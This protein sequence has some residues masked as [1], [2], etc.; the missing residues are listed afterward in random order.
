MSRA[1]KISELNGKNILSKQEIESLRGKVVV[2]DTEGE[3]SK[4]LG[5]KEKGIYGIKFR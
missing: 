2:L 3:I 4:K 1:V 5:I